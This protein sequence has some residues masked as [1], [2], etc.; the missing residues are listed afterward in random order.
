M[1]VQILSASGKSIM[2][3]EKQLLAII[4]GK[5][6]PTT[7]KQVFMAATGMKLIDRNTELSHWSMKCMYMRPP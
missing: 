2:N 3:T 6:K 1:N 4:T 7:D 5:Q